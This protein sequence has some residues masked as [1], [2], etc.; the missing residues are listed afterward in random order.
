MSDS[1]TTALSFKL[2]VKFQREALDTEP[3]PNAKMSSLTG[4]LKERRTF[5]ALVALTESEP[6]CWTCSM[7]YS[8]DFCAKRRRS[9]VSRK[10]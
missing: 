8:C 2:E 10:W 3:L 7:R 1:S 5:F 9:S 4:W 6:V